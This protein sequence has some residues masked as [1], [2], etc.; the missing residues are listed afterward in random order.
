MA[1]VPKDPPQLEMSTAVSD[2]NR[3]I[4]VTVVCWLCLVASI[5]FFGAR[6]RIRWPLKSL[7]GKDDAACTVGVVSFPSL[8]YLILLFYSG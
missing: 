8:V 4:I 7:Y 6:V 1:E 3:G 2:N 5:L